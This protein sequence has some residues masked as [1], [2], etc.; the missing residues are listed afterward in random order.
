VFQ[1][2]TDTSATNVLLFGT[3]FNM[4]E[5]KY[6]EGYQYKITNL[7]EEN[8]LNKSIETAL[9]KTLENI[10]ACAERSRSEHDKVIRQQAETPFAETDSGTDGQAQVSDTETPINKGKSSKTTKKI[11]KQSSTPI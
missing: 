6:R 9:A 8:G 4:G 10:A 7:N 3:L 1:S 2:G 5:N 11:E